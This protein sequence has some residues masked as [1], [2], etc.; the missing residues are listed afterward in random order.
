MRRF[1]K[2]TFAF[3]LIVLA[4]IAF[5]QQ[6]SQVQSDEDKIFSFVEDSAE[7]PGGL[8]AL[9]NY[10]SRK[11]KYPKEARK[12]KIEGKVTVQFVI[13]RDGSIS[14]VEIMKGVH[15]DLD[16]EAM[17]VVKLMPKWKPGKQGGKEVRQSYALPLTFKL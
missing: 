13:E 10:L 12:A 1:I 17:R 16:N 9:T 2:I 8:G 6:Q 15:Q 5:A 7:F 3:F 11:L 14:N 4:K